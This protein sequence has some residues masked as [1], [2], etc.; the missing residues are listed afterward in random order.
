[1]LKMAGRQLGVRISGP[2][3]TGQE[4]AGMNS[5]ALIFEGEVIE[6]EEK[7]EDHQE[8]VQGQR[9]FFPLMTAIET[10]VHPVEALRRAVSR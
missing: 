8:W 9:F 4:L 6:T 2:R 10:L 3:L 1:M 5:S 7:P